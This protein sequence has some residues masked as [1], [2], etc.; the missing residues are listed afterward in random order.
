MPDLDHGL[1]EAILHAVTKVAGELIASS[2]DAMPKTHRIPAETISADRIVLVEHRARPGGGILAVVRSSWEAPGV[3]I[4]AT[5]QFSA[6]FS[7]DV[8]EIAE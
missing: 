8:P 2:L 4:E 5:P 3:P 6:K 1:V 7:P